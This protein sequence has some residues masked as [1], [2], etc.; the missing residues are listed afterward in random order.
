MMNKNILFKNKVFMI[1]LVIMIVLI[2]GCDKKTEC[3]KNG[4]SYGQWDIVEEQ[5][6]TDNGL[7]KRNCQNC[8]HF[9]TN[10]LE[11]LGHNYESIVTSPTCVDQGYTTHICKRCGDSSID[12]HIEA[13]GHDLG[14]WEE[15]YPTSYTSKGLEKKECADCSYYEQRDIPQL[16]PTP[17]VNDAIEFLIIPSKTMA[18]INLPTSIGEVIVSWKTSDSDLITTQGKIGK[19]TATNQK[20]SLQATF[21]L[22]NVSLTKMYE[23]TILGYTNE[24]KLELVMNTIS[25]PGTLE[26]NLTLPVNYSYGVKAEYFSS[27]TDYLTNDG[28]INPQ[29]EDVKVTLIVRL[30]LGSDSLD[31]KFEITIPK[32]V[33]PERSHLL[34][35]YV[36]DFN[37]TEQSGLEIKNNRLVLKD[38][39]IEATYTS[40]EI[41]TEG[42]TSLVASWAAI[43][44][45]TSTCELFVS[46][47]VNNTWSEYIT[48]GEWGLGLQNASKD[49]SNSLIKLSTDEVMVLNSKTG[50]AVKYKIVLKRDSANFDSPALSL[51]SFALE[52][53]NYSYYVRTTDLPEYV[54]YDVPKLY[55]GAVPTI[56]NSICSPTS[57][58]MMLKYKGLSFADKDTEFEHRYIASIVRD[59]GNNI[60]GNWVYNTV[61][62]GAYGFNAYVARMYS[63]DELRYYLANVGPV[64]LTVKGTMISTEKTY[65]TGGHLI[66]AIGYKY[67]DD[68]LYII[69]NDPNVP[70]VYC[71]YNL[72][73]INNTWRKVAYIM[74]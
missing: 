64:A 34:V 63:V 44:S 26:A 16:D 7:L 43:S 33:E 13:I 28:E 41:S 8:D 39:V 45:T 37:L 58:T 24:E 61:T 35:E 5:T 73:V 54:C 9:E 57:T 15:V 38:G 46:V 59:Y 49:Q 19:R 2:T 53:P 62:M 17:V 25:F 69:C 60:Y 70:N 18:D 65:T 27:N 3:D 68:E 20:V 36:E 30:T 11:A 47:K 21:T 51:V 10:E 29:N 74:E 6:C 23:I 55:Q 48:Y 66:V 40:G 71:E 72:S 12:S 22:G 32:Y 31:K 4:H 52:I 67:I 14:D 56:G 42:F 50:N 1:C